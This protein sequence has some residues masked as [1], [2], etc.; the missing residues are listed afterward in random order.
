MVCP[1]YDLCEECESKVLHVHPMIRLMEP[2]SAEK[3]K[4]YCQNFAAPKA[5]FKSLEPIPDIVDKKEKLELIEFF[6]GNKPA[7]KKIE[8]LNQNKHLGV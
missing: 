2:T 4:S 3:L 7:E 6:L 5:H 8:L 1:D